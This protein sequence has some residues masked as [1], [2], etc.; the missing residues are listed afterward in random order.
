MKHRERYLFVERNPSAG[1]I[2]LAPMLP[3][4]LRLGAVEETV[5]GLIDTGAAVSVLPW[6]VGERLGGDWDTSIPMTLTGN[7]AV[8]EARA[9]IVEGLVGEFAVR[10]LAF[11]WSK[12]DT[13]PVLLG[14]VNFLL[15]F[16]VYLSRLGRW[17]D[18]L[19]PD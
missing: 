17:F 8:A 3:L 10:R 12:S 6:S 4:R 11:A 9:L 5:S 13:I 16:D 1:I 15:A 14:Q 19:D 7:L 18:L 2:S